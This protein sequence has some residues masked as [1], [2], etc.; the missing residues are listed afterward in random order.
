MDE[1]EYVIGAGFSGYA[2]SS[3]DLSLRDDLDLSFILQYFSVELQ[4]NQEQ[5]ATLGFL[6]LKWSF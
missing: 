6:R 1:E 3:F 4:E 2:G 5:K